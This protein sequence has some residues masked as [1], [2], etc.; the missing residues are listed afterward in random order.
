[1]RTETIK[2]PPDARRGQNISTQKKNW[3]IVNPNRTLSFKAVQ[4]ASLK[5]LK[6]ERYLV[7]RIT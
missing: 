5:G 3:R 2:L 1:M 7:F 4:V 6:K